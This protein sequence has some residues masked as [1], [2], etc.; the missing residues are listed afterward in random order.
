MWATVLAGLLLAAPASAAPGDLDPLFD[1]DGKL[2]SNFGRAINDGAD[3]AVQGDDKLVVTG[4]G[5]DFS[6]DWVVAR[7]NADGSLD[8][9][10]G[11]GGRVVTAFPGGDD[12][13]RAVAMAPG[14]KIVVVGQTRR[15]TTTDIAVARYNADGS[16]DTTFDSDGRATTNLGTTPSVGDVAVEPDGDIVVVGGDSTNFF[17]ARFTGAGALDTTLGGDGTVTTDFGGGDVANAVALTATQIVVTGEVR[18]SSSAQSDVGVARYSLTDGGLDTTFSTDGK[19]STSFGANDLAD[20]VA[21]LGDGRI[22]V[23]GRADGTNDTFALARF[24]VDGDLDPTFSTDG[25]QTTDFAD[26]TNETATGVAVQGDGKLAVAGHTLA[27]GFPADFAVARYTDAGDL[28]TTFSTDGMQTTDFAAGRDG[29]QAIGVDSASRIVAAGTTPATE[30]DN[31]IGLARY[32]TSGELDTTFSGDGRQATNAGGTTNTGA[33]MALQPDG[34][35][36]SV[37]RAGTAFGVARH[38]ADGSLDTGFGEGGSVTT[39]FSASLDEAVGVA[40][41]PDGKIVVVG[42][43][44]GGIAVARYT[45]A[46]ALDNTFSGD[47]THTIGPPFSVGED[48]AVQPDGKIV[49]VG[50]FDDGPDTDLGVVRLTESGVL[51]TSFSGDGLQSTDFGP[52]GFA[53]TVALQPNGAI[54]VG[55]GANDNWALGRYTSAGELDASFSGDGKQTLNLAAYDLLE[56]IA[57]AP[58]GNIVVAGRAGSTFAVARYTGAGELDNT[59]SGDGRQTTSFTGGF[60]Y[61][62]GIALQGD[63]KIVVAGFAGASFSV[64][65][66]TIVRYTGAGELDSTFGGGD[67]AVFTDFGGE[68]SASAVAIQADGNI[69]AVGSATV[70]GSDADLAITRYQGGGTALDTDGDGL[71]DVNDNCPTVTNPGQADADSDGTGDACEPPPPGTGQPPTNPPAGNPPANS[72]PPPASSQ[73]P[74]NTQQ[75][76]DSQVAGAAVSGAKTAKLG[77]KGPA[78][79]TK[80]SATSERLRA[81]VTGAIVTQG[82]KKKFALGK[83]TTSINAGRSATLTQKLAGSKSK[84]KAALR[85]LKRSLKKR[86]KVQA[87]LTIKVTDAAGNVRSFTRTIGIT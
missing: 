42:K 74:S 64:S 76:I 6:S 43:T 22:V 57:I 1:A 32:T 9:G 11:S 54:L 87:K 44:G 60:G 62:Q 75:V 2:T 16:L 35:I 68:D 7:H 84:V 3:M 50:T 71:P 67:G 33:G 17:V 53:R 48:V 40:V 51:D 61:G 15:N 55:G 31:D 28:D 23:A 21:L 82:S 80:V 8:S 29:A 38:L 70:P 4:S 72:T 30:G 66:F 18:L 58:G 85:A 63:G 37:G 47:G 78:V 14:G 10:F 65:D 81:T 19:M 49:V 36:V 73:T 39:E 59:F 46:G 20:D 79:K 24:E 25:K 41:Q 86:K 5:G 52:N 27:S 77:G 69:V 13:A 26:S 56:D 45:A 34:K 83:T 12:A